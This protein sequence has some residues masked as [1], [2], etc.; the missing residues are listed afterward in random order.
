MNDGGARERQ[1]R[2]PKR[3]VSCC[4]TLS[5]V[6]LLPSLPQCQSYMCPYMRADEPGAGALAAAI[7]EVICLRPQVRA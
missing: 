6:F 1:E 5:F 7:L 4:S 2:R 3:E